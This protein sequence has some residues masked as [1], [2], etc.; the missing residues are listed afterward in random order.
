MTNGIHSGKVEVGG[1]GEVARLES[2]KMRKGA[3]RSLVFFRFYSLLAAKWRLAMP[4][5]SNS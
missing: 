1:G 4:E 3:N 2:G 5:L